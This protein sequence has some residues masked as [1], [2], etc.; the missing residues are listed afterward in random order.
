MN[1]VSPRGTLSM[2]KQT[3]GIPGPQ[4]VLDRGRSHCMDSVWGERNVHRP[5]HSQSI[6]KDTEDFTYQVSVRARGNADMNNHIHTHTHIQ[7][8]CRES[9][10]K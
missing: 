10:G 3:H 6:L 9:G 5:A 8:Q 7:K 4:Q 2:A 1:E